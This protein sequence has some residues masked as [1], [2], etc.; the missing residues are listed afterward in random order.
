MDL[1]LDPSKYEIARWKTK[2]RADICQ[3]AT[4]AK[5]EIRAH[6]EKEGEDWLIKKDLA[7][8]WLFVH[9]SWTVD[10]A[11]ICINLI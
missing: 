5:W 11:A 8:I 6:L 3:K 9:Q 2:K 7:D 4:C 10:N 1:W